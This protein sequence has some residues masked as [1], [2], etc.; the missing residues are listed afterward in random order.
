MRVPVIGQEAVIDLPEYL[1]VICNVLDYSVKAQWTE[2]EKLIVIITDRHS[3][4]KENV[5]YM[6]QNDEFDIE[7][8]VTPAIQKLFNLS[9]PSPAEATNHTSTVY[10]DRYPSGVLERFKAIVED[11][12]A[13]RKVIETKHTQ[14]D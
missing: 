9:H 7:C 6:P 10:A 12:I 14:G 3:T 5:I 11:A 4:S 2:Q 13:K 1:D 8:V